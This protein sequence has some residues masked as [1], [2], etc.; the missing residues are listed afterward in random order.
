[1]FPYLSS[2]NPFNKCESFGFAF[3]ARIADLDLCLHVVDL[4]DL[5]SMACKHS[6]DLVDVLLVYFRR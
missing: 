1:M 2:G 6:L 3:Y 5:P 4:V